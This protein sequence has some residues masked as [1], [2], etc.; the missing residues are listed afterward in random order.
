MANHFVVDLSAVHI[1]TMAVPP[2]LPT[3]GPASKVSL[4]I[5]LANLPNLDVMSKTDAKV[6]VYMSM[7]VTRDVKIGQTEKAKDNLNPRFA[8]PIVLDYYFESV[9]ELYFVVG[10]VDD[11]KT[12]GIG[13]YRCSLGSIVGA[14]GQQITT[15]LQMARPHY[16]QATITIR[17][18]EVRG[19]N[20]SVEFRWSGSQLDSTSS[21]SCFSHLR[22]L[23]LSISGVYSAQRANSDR[24]NTRLCFPPS[25]RLTFPSQTV[26]FFLPAPWSSFLRPLLAD[27]PFLE[28]DVG[29][30]A[31]SDPYFTINKSNPDGT[32]TL[33]YKSDYKKQTL[34]PVWKEFV[35]PLSHLCG[36]DMLRPLVIEV[37]D[38]DKHSDH[39]LIGIIN[40][41]ADA[42]TKGKFFDIINPKKQS[43]KSYKNSGIL[44]IDHVAIVQDFSFLDYLAGGVQLNLA[45]GVDYTASNGNPAQNNSLHFRAPGVRNAYM[46]VIFSVGNILLPYDYDGWVPAYGFGAKLNATGQTS[47]CFPINGA[48]ALAPRPEVPGVQGLLDAYQNSFNLLTLHGPTNMAPIINTIAAE[49]SELAKLGSDLSAYLLMLIITDG[50]ITDMPATLEAV[51]QASNLP[52]SII[53][54]GVGNADFTNMNLLDSDDGHLKAPSGSKAIRDIVQFVPFNKFANDPA[55]LAAE[56][57]AELPKQVVQYMKIKNIKPR[58][59][60]VVQETVITQTTT[61]LAGAYI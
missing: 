24:K 50:E 26:I 55:R 37:W 54:V 52:M 31:K 11:H 33:V 19:A 44:S 18:E 16:S 27:L 30:F 25:S 29:L 57:L 6:L 59:R 47:F 20:N 1:L 39:D 53:L 35:I 14:R 5:S 3:L 9:Q 49:A 10:D 56:T 36:G 41:N 32:T 34:D 43:K 38:W 17:A 51:V 48:P 60:L 42:L 46:D 22:K 45:V 58:P 28:K 61:A 8:T 15:N 21:S 4:S 2:A 40:T 23:L 7:G 13:A 12:E